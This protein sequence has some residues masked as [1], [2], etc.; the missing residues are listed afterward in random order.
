MVIVVLR[1]MQDGCTVA[2]LK[3]DGWRKFE[4]A[5]VRSLWRSGSDVEAQVQASNEGP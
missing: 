5:A 4:W 1:K 2:A 3:A